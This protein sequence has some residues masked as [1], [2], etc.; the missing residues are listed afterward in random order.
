MQDEDNVDQGLVD[1]DH[2]DNNSGDMQFTNRIV[3]SK[4]SG[5]TKKPLAFCNNKV[6]K[7]LC[8]SAS[9]IEALEGPNGF[10]P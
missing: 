3:L 6:P 1:E 7:T 4:L 5:S 8:I 10:R 9:A 2:D